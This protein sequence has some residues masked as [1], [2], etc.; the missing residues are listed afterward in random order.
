MNSISVKLKSMNKWSCLTFELASELS[1]MYELKMNFEWW[2]PPQK[3]G[4]QLGRE[5]DTKISSP[6][7]FNNTKLKKE[8]C[9]IFSLGCYITE[10]LVW[11]EMLSVTIVWCLE[12]LGYYKVASFKVPP[13]CTIRREMSC[14][15]VDVYCYYAPVTSQPA[16]SWSTSR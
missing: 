10:K 6:G 7:S 16:M 1:T 15:G 4:G 8:P 5:R 13:K 2:C 9:T 3:K 11:H 12:Y 14:S